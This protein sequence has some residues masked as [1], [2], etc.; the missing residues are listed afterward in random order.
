MTIVRVSVARIPIVGGGLM[1][2]QPADSIDRNQ[3]RSLSN[4]I[5][6]CN[7]VG[8]HAAR[9][10]SFRAVK[11]NAFCSIRT[12]AI[13]NGD[14]FDIATACGRAV[15]RPSSPMDVAK[16]RDVVQPPA[17]KV[18][19]DDD[20]DDD[21]ERFSSA[22]SVDSDA[23]DACSS[24]GGA[25]CSTSTSSSCSS[26]RTAITVL[27]V[28]EDARKKSRAAATPPPPDVIMHHHNHGGNGGGLSHKGSRR[29][30]NGRRRSSTGVAVDGDAAQHDRDQRNDA[31]QSPTA[32]ADDDSDGS[33]P[34]VDDAAV[35]DE[36]PDA[37][38]SVTS[39]SPLQPRQV[40]YTVFFLL[41]I[42]MF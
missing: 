14:A 7:P 21:E 6:R 24:D 23:R 31:E 17:I 13:E 19:D 41:L 18:A 37:S 22:E 38:A 4:D 29:R 15:D 2:G 34:A 9:R 1:R 26:Q 30:R 12:G 16:P 20:D 28:D 35:A 32:A 8:P 33:I 42:K 10:R 11:L 27:D 25:D 39:T 3:Y 5:R 40:G 36:E